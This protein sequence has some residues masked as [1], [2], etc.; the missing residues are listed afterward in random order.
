MVRGQVRLDVVT[1]CQGKEAK[2]G[3]LC[4]L[5][6]IPAVPIAYGSL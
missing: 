2:A 6:S 4:A 1:G 5:Q 3:K